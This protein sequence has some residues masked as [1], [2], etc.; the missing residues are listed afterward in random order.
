MKKNPVALIL[1]QPLYEKGDEN[2]EHI[3]AI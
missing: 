2:D 3:E 1:R